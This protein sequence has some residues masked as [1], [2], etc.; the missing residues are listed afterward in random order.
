[1]NTYIIGCA[2]ALAVATLARA[3]N[4]APIL[5]MSGSAGTGAPVQGMGKPGT[6]AGTP[7]AEA[8]KAPVR[9]IGA[10]GKG[11]GIGQ[12]ATPIEVVSSL[13][14]AS[15]SSIKV[16][17]STSSITFGAPVKVISSL[18][19]GAPAATVKEGTTPTVKGVAPKS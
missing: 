2:A 11:E 14:S 18:P 13:N 5:T 16:A 10:A 15:T 12:S 8:A 6:V 17:A 9:S 19:S 1:M 7:T 3:D 4:P